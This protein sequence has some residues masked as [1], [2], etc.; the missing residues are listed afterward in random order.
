MN[1]DKLKAALDRIARAEA[2]GSGQIAGCARVLARSPEVLTRLARILEGYE[3]DDV[4]A[5]LK[6]AGWSV[7]PAGGAFYVRRKAGETGLIF[8]NWFETDADAWAAIRRKVSR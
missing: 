7:G 1:T 4:N 8:N 5:D 3:P 2:S 6:A